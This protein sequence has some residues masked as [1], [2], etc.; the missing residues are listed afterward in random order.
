MK[1]RWIS[2]VLTGLVLVS[3]LALPVAAAENGGEV[4]APTESQPAPT[5]SQ[6]APTES[7]PAPT[8][9]QPAPTESQPAPTESSPTAP[10]EGGDEDC[11][12]KWIGGEVVLEPTCQEYGAKGYVCAKCGAIGIE[13][14][15][16]APHTY[17]SPCDTDCNVCGAVRDAEHKFGTGWEYNSTK[18][19]H[20]CSLCGAKSAEADHYP[21]PAA[22]E[23]KDQICM[24]CGKIMTRK[25]SHTHKEAAAWTS[26]E[27]G[28]W[29]ACTGCDE[30]LGFAPHRF[31]GAC[32]APCLDCGY[33]PADGHAYG[34][35]W[36]SD[37]TDHWKTCTLCGEEGPREPHFIDPET[38]LCTL[39]AGGSAAEA[40]HVH[41]FSGQW[42]ADDASHWNVCACGQEAE[43]Y[44]HAWKTSGPDASGILTYTCNTCGFEKTEAAP[45]VPANIPAK[46]LFVVFIAAIAVL[47]IVLVVVL[48][49]F[50][51]PKKGHFAK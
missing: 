26:D 31:E 34:G 11:D 29:H 43:R 21:G 8:E 42:M 41:E 9:S 16:L 19:W 38:G 40:A 51:K 48:L 46:T 37:E 18:H 32:D 39:C 24:T 14:I 17:D 2:I 33:I 35:A 3:L 5:E 23:E 30:K 12:H 49:S 7:Q 22:T 36:Y 25:L 4:P 20:V 15:D 44:P 1:K 47:L 13:P 6:P 10:S 28:H 45:E 27:S 50:R